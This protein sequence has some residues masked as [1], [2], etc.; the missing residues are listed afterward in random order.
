MN[1]L[2]TIFA[3]KSTRAYVSAQISDES[4]EMILRAAFA[5]PVAMARY[6]SLHITVVQNE[7]LIKE[8]GFGKKEKI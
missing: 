8:L 4:L 2:D 7:E 5:S 3:R 6:D 1:T